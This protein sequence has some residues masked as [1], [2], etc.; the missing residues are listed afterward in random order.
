MPVGRHL[1]MLLSRTALPVCL[2]AGMFAS[3]SGED[4]QD[5]DISDDGQDPAV[6]DE[7]PLAPTFVLATLEGEQV[8]LE[9]FR[10]KVVVVSFWATW[11][12][13]CVEEMPH[14]DALRVEIG[15]E[16]MEILAIT[17]D[18]NPT[19]DVPLFLEE[20]GGLSFPIL[21][22]TREV[23]A[24]YNVSIGLPATYVVDRD[25]RVVETLIGGQDLSVFEPLVRKHL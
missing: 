13:P 7:G 9:E 6:S 22:G 4:A 23:V 8:A 20:V 19:E 1:A 25:G 12:A 2:V 5:P 16:D 11:C 24:D 21:L 15:P 14:L 3:G 18:E 10:G 17:V